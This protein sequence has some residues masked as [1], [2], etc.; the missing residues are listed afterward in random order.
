MANNHSDLTSLFTDIADAIRSKTGGSDP[1]IAD[2][3]PEAI[4]GIESGGGSDDGFPIGDGNTHLW[5]T[6]PEGR[7]APMVGLLVNGTVTVDWGDGS[8]VDILI[9]T[10]IDRAKYT[11][12]HVYE[13]AGDYV[14]SLTVDGE[15]NAIQNGTKPEAFIFGSTVSNDKSNQVYAT[16]VKK[17]EI[18]K[19]FTKVPQSAFV[20]AHGLSEVIIPEGITEIGDNA[21][22]ENLCLM[23]VKFPESLTTI[24]SSAFYNTGLCSVISFPPSVNNIKSQAFNYSYGILC[25]DFTKHTSIPTLGSSGLMQYLPDFCEI[26]V[27]SALVND[28]KSA[29]NWAAHGDNI[30]GV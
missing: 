11:P 15:V 3:F 1:I 13:K 24:G 28:W 20:K 2:Q 19:N 25:F 8:E 27:P 18:G 10:S 14:I 5:V 23:N 4:E 12:P 30:V 9:G 7:T 21:F 16:T 26:R 6:L 17:V 29:T 22:Y